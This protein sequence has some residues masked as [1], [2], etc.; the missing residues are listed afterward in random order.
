MKGFYFIEE[1][2]IIVYLFLD[3]SRASPAV[4]EGEADQSTRCPLMDQTSLRTCWS[5]L[6]HHGREREKEREG[7]TGDSIS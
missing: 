1:R 5:C 2:G 7:Q 3:N 6:E 4:R